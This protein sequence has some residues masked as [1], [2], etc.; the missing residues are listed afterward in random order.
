MRNKKG[1]SPDQYSSSEQS[2]KMI[3][4]NL[5]HVGFDPDW[6]SGVC[7]RRGGLFTAIEVK[8][9]E[10]VLWMQSGHTQTA[11]ARTYGELNSPTL[12]Y[13]AWGA[14]NL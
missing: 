2:A 9:P 4:N 11:A 7:A 5:T 8:V 1:S 13:D 10:H 12:L 3:V 14:F 6:F